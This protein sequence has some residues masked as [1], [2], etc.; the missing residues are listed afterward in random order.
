MDR[1]EAFEALDV[2]AY[3][4]AIVAVIVSICLSAAVKSTFNKYRND[5]ISSGMSGGDIA[6]QIL[7]TAGIHNV[8]VMVAPGAVP[9]YYDRKRR[10][11]WL[12]EPVAYGHSISDIAAAAYECGHA[13]QHHEGY[14]LFSFRNIMAPVAKYC[15]LGGIVIFIF[16]FALSGLWQPGAIMMGAALLFYIVTSPVAF[17]ASKRALAILENER[18]IRYDEVQ[19]TKIVLRAAAL[20][21][22]ANTLE[23]ILDSLSRVSCGNT[24]SDTNPF[25]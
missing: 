20:A 19:R 25:M 17:D 23:S 8:L 18:L 12:S 1:A 6:Q 13:I 2:W 24:D 7:A 11:L 21:Y 16:G 14:R 10:V 4:T 3:L 5:I 15:L 22:S 9:D